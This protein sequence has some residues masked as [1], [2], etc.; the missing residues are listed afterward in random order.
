MAHA[1]PVQNEVAREN[2][3]TL[4][5]LK[6]RAISS[7]LNVCERTTISM[8]RESIANTIKAIIVICLKFVNKVRTHAFCCLHK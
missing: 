4:S 6:I 5:D 8:D 2:V 1:P 3:L 7:L